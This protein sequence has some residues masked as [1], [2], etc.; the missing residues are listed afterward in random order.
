MAFLPQP[1]RS[2]TRAYE[3]LTQQSPKLRAGI[4]AFYVRTEFLL[5]VCPRIANQDHAIRRQMVVA[6]TF[7]VGG[8]RNALRRLPGFANRLFYNP[9]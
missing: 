8:L 1:I 7:G 9:R 6:N 2:S 4:A 3:A 5:V